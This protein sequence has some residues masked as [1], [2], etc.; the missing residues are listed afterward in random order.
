[1]LGEYAGDYFDAFIGVLRRRHSPVRR[2][3]LR[4]LRARQCSC[5]ED[6]GPDGCAT[7]AA[8]VA[9]LAKLA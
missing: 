5:G 9:K 8:A 1:M 4:L 2:G 3:W 7:L 6:L